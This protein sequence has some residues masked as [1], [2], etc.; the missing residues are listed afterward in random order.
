MTSSNSGLTSV[1]IESINRLLSEI[2]T[3]DENSY[4]FENPRQFSDYAKR[5]QLVLNQFLGSSSSENSN[6]PPQSALTALRGLSGDLKKSVETVS[7]YKN[8]S[9]IYILINCISLCSSLQEH[10]VAISGWL[11]LIEST[12]EDDPDL[13]KKF[14]DLSRDMSQAEFK[15]TE[16]EERVHC[17]LQKEGEG[18]QTTKAVQSAIIMDLAR[19]LGI[20]SKNH[21]ELSK[22]INL[23]KAD[24]SRSNSVSERRILFSLE[25]IINN[26][27]IEPDLSA[28]SLDT[29][30]E[31]DAQITPFKNFLCPLTK[32]VMKDP[33]VLESHQTYERSAIEYW[34]RRC[35]QDGRDPTCP[36]TGQVLK[37]LEHKPNIGLA[38]AIEEWMNRNVDI[39][40]KLSVNYLTQE[41]SPSAECIQRVLDCI[42]RISE[43][44]P[45][46][47][48]KVRNAGL[49]V[50]IVNLLRNSSKSIGTHLRAKALMTLLSMANDDESKKIM[51]EEG[52]TRLAIHSLTGSSEKEREIAVKLLLEFSRDEAYCVK[53]ASEKGALV[54]LSSM[55]VTLEYP[56]L[57]NLAEEVLKRI[58]KVEDNVLHLAAAGRFEPLLCRLSEGLVCLDRFSITLLVGTDAVKIEM[59][60]MVGKM[61]LTN[62]SKEQIARK[63]AKILVEML[64]KPDGRA[65]SLQALNNLSSLSDNATILVDAAML[66]ALTGILFDSQDTSP[67]LKELASSIISNVVSKPGHWELAVAD[68][69]GHLLQ[70]ESIVVRLLGLLSL[71]SLQCQLSILRILVGIASSPQASGSVVSCL[72]SGD[73]IKTV[74]PFLEHEEVEHRIYAFRLTRV[75]SKHMSQD[76]V[77][78]L[79][80]CD[81]LQLLKDKLLNDQSTD[82]E[83]SD[84]AS[85]L[86]NLPLSEEEVKTVLRVDMLRRTIT[87][88]KDEFCS[89]RERTTRTTSSTGEGLLCLSLHFLKNPD[90]E[91]LSI[92][93]ELK[94]MT[95]FREQ[96]VFSLKPKVKQLS[97][98][99]LKYLSESGRTVIVSVDSEPQIP[100]GLCS[101]LIFMCGRRAS[102]EPTLCPVHNAPC[103]TE[104]Q[105]CLLKSSCI[106]PLSDL[107]L[108]D[109]DTNVQ[110]A[111]VEALSTLLED[112]SDNLIHVVDELEQLGVVNAVLDL[113]T[114]VRTGILQERTIW[115]LERI[116]RVENLNHKHALNEGLVRALVETLRH[117]NAN[118]KRH[119]QDALTNLKQLS[120]IG[121]KSSQSSGGR[122]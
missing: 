38:G 75:I 60:S 36:V 105:F 71:A 6:F 104:S 32:E 22:H 78:E 16:N 7:V 74:I 27:S 114:E 67:E 30:F 106:K 73:G 31:D 52:I 121:G 93:G 108:P 58:E 79:R 95:F 23:L 56:A 87:I 90:F 59:A 13:R 65:S 42:Y 107:L 89:A 37:S 69:Q 103:D 84:A 112:T 92:V 2:C 15:V 118:A 68:K 12:L 29:D 66:P 111:A 55:A 28:Q 26:W 77:N 34:F 64:A 113:F 57:S 61:T 46:S 94:L 115:M 25:R 86:G 50:L 99:G 40:V 21:L 83:R 45:S 96:L 63:S 18:R 47:R 97:A 17:T 39:Q 44:Y 4:S 43:E 101:S 53:I 110:I 80:T 51:L 70:S 20:D 117:G 10:A 122:R 91:I 5:L 41:P 116:L 19:A 88:L 11:A 14:A 82:S 109:N 8:K 72:K 24:L 100:Q 1:V 3:W 76:L 98:L 35:L 48:Y 102:P 33:V 120:A 119:A 9:K 62:T 81:K 54:L 49:V 85:I